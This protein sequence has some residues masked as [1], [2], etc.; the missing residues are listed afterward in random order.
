MEDY[1]AQNSPASGRR[2]SFFLKKLW[3][4]PLLTL[5]LAVGAAG[6][7]IYYWAPPHF[8]SVASMWET[9]KL[10]LADGAS[11]TD[12]FQD[13]FGTQME[14]LRN[15]L[16]QR[17]IARMQGANI[18][19][20]PL[21][22]D[23]RPIK[24]EVTVKQ[25]PKS[26]VLMIE[27]DSSEPAF[28]QAYLTALLQEYTEY[29]KGVRKAVSGDTLEG[30]S[31]QVDP[32]DQDLKDQQM[33]LT[34]FEQT[35]N[36][37]ILQE[38]GRIDGGYLATQQTKLSDLRQELQLLDA[39]ARAAAAAIGTTNVSVPA[40]GADAQ[41]GPASLAPV[42]EI[43]LLKNE[44]AKLSHNLRPEHPK[45][46]KLDAQ[47]ERDEQIITMLRHEASDQ[48]AA[49]RE[50][51]KTE[52]ANLTA[53]IKEWEA[54]IVEADRRIAEAE[55]LKAAVSRTQSLRDRLDSL[56]QNVSISRNIDQETLTTLDPAS[57][58][59]RSYS[60]EL[61][62]LLGSSLGG[63]LLGF[64]LVAL[65][66]LR[67]DRFTT[68]AD[69]NDKFG[70]VIV[71]QVP[72]MPRMRGKIRMPLLEL[73]DE[74][75]MYAESYR[76][77]R[78]AILFMPMEGGP[79]KV[80]LITS[81]LPDEGK[82]TI[83]ANLARTLASGGA[84]VL[85]IDGDLRR[86]F[87]HDLLGMR[88]EPGLPDLM[89]CPDDMDSIIQ[90]DSMPNFYFLSRGRGVTNPGDFFLSPKVEQLLVR[91]RK[92]FDFIVI[93]SSPIFAADDAVSLAPKTDGTLFVVRSRYSPAGAVKEALELLGQ[94]QIRVLGLVFNRAQS[95][96]RS[97]YYYKHSDYYRPQKTA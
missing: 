90:Q 19:A 56:V 51:I 67:D 4:V 2:I 62:L 11:F 96:G 7:Y 42:Q 1:A 63:L 43:E 55:A 15:G 35:N 37:A 85:L 31:R 33:A 84:R 66:G 44:R 54:T 6:A 73:E 68:L 30:I 5:A 59:K 41:S 34:A 38:Q 14:L 61:R 12:N 47:I 9:E 74:R 64:G 16:E 58:A 70:D 60:S 49:R 77:L 53:S 20:I 91:L 10:H 3:W 23:G 79:P 25:A 89:N 69:V 72:D 48:V 36:L 27:T 80:L 40:A 32:V 45:I 65:V 26:T 88:L 81:A 28:S 83:S 78:S 57:P 50:S 93:D 86:G 87:L 95:S 94:R 92:K 52:I 29:K 13:Y 8:V 97:Y 18:H 75:Y 24:A 22:K 17:V 71:G 46:V 21:G 76:S 82:S 39:S